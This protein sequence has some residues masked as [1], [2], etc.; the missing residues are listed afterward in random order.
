M[1]STANQRVEHPPQG[2][3][4]CA[5]HSGCIYAR[6]KTAAGKSVKVF[7]LKSRDFL[8]FDVEFIRHRFYIILET[9]EES[10]SLVT[11]HQHYQAFGLKIQ[12]IRK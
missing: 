10:S 4:G 2:A 3:P 9:G 6:Y 1:F 12:E 8:V 5:E 11:I 7:L